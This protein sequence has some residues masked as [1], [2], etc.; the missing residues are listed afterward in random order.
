M[1]TLLVPEDETLIRC[2]RKQSRKS[3]EAV[4]P[5][6]IDI[7]DRFAGPIADIRFRNGIDGWALARPAR[8]RVPNICVANVS[9]TA[10]TG[11]QRKEF[12]AT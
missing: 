2:A 7:E 11:D 3:G 10:R 12:Q 6:L 8:E 1:L 4:V 9:A 5:L